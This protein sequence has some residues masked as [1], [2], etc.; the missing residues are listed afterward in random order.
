MNFNFEK[1]RIIL[2]II[3]VPENNCIVIKKIIIIITI[4]VY[5][6]IIVSENVLIIDW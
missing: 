3:K 4:F 6:P 2:I 1:Y 5:V